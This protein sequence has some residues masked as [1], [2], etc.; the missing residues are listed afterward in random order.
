LDAISGNIC[1]CTGYKSIER[2]AG[3][4]CDTLDHHPSGFPMAV[5]IEKGIVPAYFKDIPNRL[6][7]IPPKSAAES[8]NKMVHGGTDIYVQKAGTLVDGDVRNLG[9]D[10]RLQGIH[11]EGNHCILGAGTTVSDLWNHAE[12]NRHF[13]N[14]KAHLTLVSS[15]Q[16]R[17]MASLGGN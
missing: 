14:L 17:N 2:A 10:A 12:L 16:I 15:E 5:L 4:L 11:I 7:A 8:N 3:Q 9:H 1:R 6:K 13:P